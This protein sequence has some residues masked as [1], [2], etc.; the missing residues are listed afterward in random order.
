MFMSFYNVFTIINTRLI[1]TWFSCTHYQHRRYKPKSKRR[2]RNTPQCGG[3]L[4]NKVKSH[5][6]TFTLCGT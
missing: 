6:K 2:E 5:N 3:T 1:A 4:I